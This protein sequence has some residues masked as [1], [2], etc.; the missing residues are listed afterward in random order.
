MQQIRASRYDLVGISR[1]VITD[2]G[3]SRRVCFRTRTFRRT[4]WGRCCEVALLSDY[5]TYHRGKRIEA[6]TRAVVV[7]NHFGMIGVGAVLKRPWLDRN[8][9]L[10]RRRKM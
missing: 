3:S 5:I 4:S 7:A 6:T 9:A 1:R 10:R 8:V 2:V